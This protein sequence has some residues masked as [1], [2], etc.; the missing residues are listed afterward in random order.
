VRCITFDMGGTSTDVALCD[1]ALPTTTEGEIAGLPLRLPILDIHTVGAGGGSIA[2]IDAG[3]ALIVG[4]ESAGADPGPACYGRGGALPTVTDANLVLGRLDA[5][6]FLGGQMRLDIEAAER[7][8]G[9]LAENLSQQSSLVTH[10]S[11]LA[12]GIV[13]VANATMERAI[14]KISVERGHDPRRFTLVAFGGAGPLHACELAESLGIPRVLV[15][16]APGV[17]S[18][19]GMATADTIKDYSRGV[20][21][22]VDEI[23]ENEFESLFT[24]MESRGREELLA[25]GIDEADMTLQRALDLRYVGQSYEITVTALEAR[26]PAGASTNR[27]DAIGEPYSEKPG[28]L[29]TFHPLHAMRY[30]HSHPDRAVE[31]VA[32]RVKA[33]GKAQRV[34]MAEEAS[35]DEEA[36]GAIVGQKPVWFEGRL[37][38]S[39]LYTRDQL[40]AGH[41]VRGPA[42]V[43]QF[44]TTS[45]IPPG[46]IAR[47]D[48]F[49]N[50]ICERA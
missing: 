24:E 48:R 11:S 30:G 41:L 27:E 19:L 28:F 10:H 40:H 17:L 5:D 44:D 31:V 47:V 7:A 38:D 32:A 34:E 22:K 43:F 1:G 46:W 8:I 16:P 9:A 23:A 29:N 21:R 26:V 15:P 42:I 12:W 36:S 33:I 50:L 2:R 14:R 37:I 39:A 20:L 6:H 18:A 45:V 35:M 13:R 4:P 49:K 25:E 3:G